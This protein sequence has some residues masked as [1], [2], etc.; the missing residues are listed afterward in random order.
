[1]QFRQAFI[2]LFLTSIL[3][4]LSTAVQA[5]NIKCWKN[6][7]GIR[8]C[9]SIVPPEYSQKR[10][11]IVN[12]RGLVVKVIEAAKTPEQLA[13][14]RE[15]EQA[16]KLK[17]QQRKEQA[18]ID[19]ILLN[20]YTTER[21]LLLARDNNLKSAQAQIDITKGNLKVMQT[22]LDK[23]QVRAANYERSGKQPPEKLIAEIDELKTQ[24]Q[25]KLRNI[26]KQEQNYQV[27][28]KRFAADLKRFR[29]LKSGRVAN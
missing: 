15:A 4:S 25:I 21:D 8:G 27:M 11:E 9:G 17:E 29:E 7:I 6:D 26:K 5:R 13:A 16:R 28:E 2:L 10:I 1:M 20:A 14:E 22:N 3:V 24:V 19:A 18:R 23:L 12:E